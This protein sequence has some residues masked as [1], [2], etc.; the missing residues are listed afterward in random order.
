MECLRR[1]HAGQRVRSEFAATGVASGKHSRGNG[2]PGQPE[3]AKARARMQ[4]L[5]LA[6]AIVQAPERDAPGCVAVDVCDEQHA[7]RRFTRWRKR[8]QFGARRL[9]F[10]GRRSVGLRARSAA[11]AEAIDAR[12]GRRALFPARPPG[13]IV[14]PR[15]AH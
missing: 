12:V 10:F 5:H 4:P 7:L 14:R 11:V 6:D 8:R 1:R 13:R 2:T 3:A 9:S 15:R